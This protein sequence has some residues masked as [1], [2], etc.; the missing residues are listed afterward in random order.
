[1]VLGRLTHDIGCKSRRLGKPEWVQ[2]PLGGAEHWRGKRACARGPE[3]HVRISEPAPDYRAY[4]KSALLR[5]E[6]LE[7]TGTAAR[8]DAEPP[9]CFFRKTSFENRQNAYLRAR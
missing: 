1:M 7:S 5:I 4:R 9:G 3:L 6:Q 8:H 2:L